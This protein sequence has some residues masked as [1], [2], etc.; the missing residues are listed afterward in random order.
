V[1]RQVSPSTGKVY[2][3]RRV[4][5]LRGVARATLHRHRRPTG[6]VGREGPGPPGAMADDDPAVATRQLLT[7]APFMARVAASSG[8][9]YA[10]PASAPAGAAS[11]G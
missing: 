9:G 5:R 8:P 7:D 10:S 4:A 2:G 3:L 1:S 11:R 6:M